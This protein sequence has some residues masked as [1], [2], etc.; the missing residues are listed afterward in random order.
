[1]ALSQLAEYF[2]PYWHYGGDM[3]REGTCIIVGDT[4]SDR[5]LFWNAHHR[6]EG[7]SFS[8]VTTLRLPTARTAD[9]TFL[10]RIT[11]IIQQHGVWD[12]NGKNNHINLCS[13]SLEREEL[14]AVAV[15]LRERDKWLRVTVIKHADHAAIV[16]GFGGHDYIH[17]RMG[18]AAGEPE[19]QGTAEFYGKRVLLPIVLPWH[20]KESMPPASA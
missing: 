15:R 1:M 19:A 6:F 3:E 8:D 13:C 5:L 12:H 14:E 4:P 17:F 10:G 11:Q 16:P 20:M 7:L 2:A 18:G 9:D